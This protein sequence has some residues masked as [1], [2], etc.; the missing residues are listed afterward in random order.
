MESSLKGRGQRVTSERVLRAFFFSDTVSSSA[1]RDA[2]LQRHGGKQ[3]HE[4]YREECLEGS[5]FQSR[6]D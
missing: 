6:T 5:A 1:I 4:K 3:G 2:H